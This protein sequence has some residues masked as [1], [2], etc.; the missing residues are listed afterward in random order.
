MERTPPIAV[1]RA[2]RREVNFGCPVEGCGKP[3]LGY[4]HFD[5][6]WAVEH[7]Q[8]PDGMVALCGEHYHLADGG[9]YTIGQIQDLK[10]APYLAAKDVEATFAYKRKH[11]AMWVGTFAYDFETAIELY[12]EKVLSIRK[13]ED[14][15]S[16]LNVLLRDAN[17]LPILGMEDDDWT[18]DP[19]LL[20]DLEVG[21]EGRRLFVK[22]RD[23]QT[24][25]LIRHHDYTRLE[26]AEALEKAR[27]NDYGTVEQV[28]AE[29]AQFIQSIGSPESIPAWRIDG[30][31]RYRDITLR[32]RG[33]EVTFDNPARRTTGIRS[34]GG[35]SVRS[36]PVLG[37][38][39]YGIGMN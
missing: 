26:L 27:K 32:I 15:Y 11:T 34:F 12:G 20:T 17:G 6:P 2:L 19:T 10:R 33:S 36:T 29:V 38:D 37:A 39:E 14:G 4:H 8:R 25:L 21:V 35:L 3:Y 16:R 1:R 31:L 28:R 18:S 24:Q 23:G 9:A 22:S 5:P 30:T 13:D 7:H